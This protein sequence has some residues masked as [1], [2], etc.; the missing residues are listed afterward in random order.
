MNR[1]HLLKTLAIAPLAAQFGGHAGRL[2]AAPAGTPRCLV[3]FLRGGYDASSL[4]V[5]TS[6]NFYY[7]SR[8][9]IAIPKPSDDLR[10]AIA[11]DADWGLHPALRE[12][13]YPLY[14]NGQAAFLPFAGTD[15]L[16]RSHFET[17][18]SIE[19]GQ[20]LTGTRN[21]RSGF[22]NRLAAVLSG[23]APIA[24]TDQ[25]P[26]AMQGE[27]QVP[28]IALRSVGKPN[29]DARQSKIIAS[30]YGNTPLAAQ[31][32]EG[33]MVRE[34]VARQFA[35]EMDAANRNAITAKGF[36]LEARRIARLMGD[37][38]TLGFVDVGGWDTHVGQGAASGYLAGRFDE[39][40][41]GLA[42]FADE[43][44]PQWRDTVVVVIS[45]FGRTFR[46]NGNRGTDHGHGSVYWLLGGGIRGGRVVGEQQRLEQATLFQ[47]RD[48]PVLNEYRAVLGGLFGRLYGLRDEQVERVFVQT[49]SKD[50]GLV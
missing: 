42:G 1:R 48:Y 32:N 6:S 25:L 26:I 35:G 41:R 44:G 20:P 38:Y 39:L 31:V 22:M 8:P 11:L 33:F 21:F 4:L 17:Q 46:E 9:N 3:V 19:L 15:D 5:P 10:S 49:K 29:V 13:I 14:R 40:G 37:K 45:E 30:M 23:A 27:V 18:D 28:N 47:N 50:I 2:F 36:E 12:S 43:M 34:D 7:Q 16:T 24:L